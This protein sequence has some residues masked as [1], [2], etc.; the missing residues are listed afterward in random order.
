MATPR[1]PGCLFLS[2]PFAT[3]MVFIHVPKNNTPTA[4]LFSSVKRV[5]F[6]K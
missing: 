1:D 5:V 4:P 6:I 3:D 2:K